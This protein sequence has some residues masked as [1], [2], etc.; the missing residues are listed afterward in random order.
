MAQSVKGERALSSRDMKKPAD[1]SSS[2]IMYLTRL[3]GNKLFKSKTLVLV[4]SLVSM[5]KRR[6]TP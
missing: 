4:V 1:L 3:D 2:P 5:V 6:I